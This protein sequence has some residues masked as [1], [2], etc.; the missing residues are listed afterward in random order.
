VFFA[1]KG[2][3]VTLISPERQLFVTTKVELR[4]P[5]QLGRKSKSLVRSSHVTCTNLASQSRRRDQT[6]S[7]PT[8]GRIA[9]ATFVL[10]APAIV[11]A[12]NRLDDSNLAGHHFSFD[13]ALDCNDASNTMSDSALE[14]ASA[15]Q[16]FANATSLQ[17]TDA[18]MCHVLQARRLLMHRATRSPSRRRHS[19]AS[20]PKQSQP[21]R[22]IQRHNLAIPPHNEYAPNDYGTLR[23]FPPRSQAYARAEPLATKRPNGSRTLLRS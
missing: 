19:H 14:A 9:N 5:C 10:G 12:S 22:R 3:R 1:V 21:Q 16:A 8:V 4:S 2:P 20:C 13:G 23:M 17:A 7:P 11:M 6:Q 15:L 18:L